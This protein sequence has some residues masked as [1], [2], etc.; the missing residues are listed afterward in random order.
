MSDSG[1]TSHSVGGGDALELGDIS[2]IRG[3]PWHRAAHSAGST[4][5]N[6]SFP[7]VDSCSVAYQLRGTA[8]S[9]LLQGF[10]QSLAV[11]SA[12]QQTKQTHKLGEN[13]PFLGLYTESLQQ[14]PLH[15][16]GN[17][18]VFCKLTSRNQ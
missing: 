6:L 7:L 18:V 17:F 5:R 2:D 15:L 4:A 13:L 1:C 3:D 11:V 12:P 8:E 9:L 14:P 10:Q 16:E